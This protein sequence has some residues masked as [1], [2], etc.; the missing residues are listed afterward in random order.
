MAFMTRDLGNYEVHFGGP[1]L[2]AYRLRDLLAERIAAVPPGGAIDWVTYYF[3]DRMLA[4]ELLRAY[5]QGVKVTLTLEK[6]PR[7]AHAND[8]VIAMLSG[9]SGLG[10][11]FRSLSLR[12]IPIPFG[13][14]R[15]PHLHEKLYCFSHPKPVAFVGSFNPSG[16]GPDDDR[17][18]I[19]EIGD[20]DRGH[21]VLVGLSDPVLVE[22]LVE[23]ARWIHGARFLL[24]SRFSKCANRAIRGK[25]IE[26]HFW[27]RVRPH[28]VLQFLRPLG[29]KARIRIAASHL[30]GA[31]VVK[32]ILELAATG[33]SVEILAEPT[34]RRV[35]LEVER[36]LTQ[37]GIPFRRVTHPEGLPMHNKFVL[38]EKGSQRWVMFGSFNWTGRSFRLSHEI[39]AISA[40]GKLF[41]AFARRW[42]ALAVRRD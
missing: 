28:P 26:I 6:H 40:N 17:A 3:R 9:R 25:D 14:A 11:G 22:R 15:R 38:A 31:S 10:S 33:A 13:K 24:L 20:Q 7:T 18:I 8:M 39:I 41:D 1:D 23:H 4:E 37:A 16:D 32:A 35:P 27:P 2:P 5:R 42:E 12:K 19:D 30:K 29:S 34:L 36:M 21:N